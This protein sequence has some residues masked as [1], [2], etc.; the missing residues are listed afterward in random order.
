MSPSSLHWLNFVLYAFVLFHWSIFRLYLLIPLR[1]DNCFILFKSLSIFTLNKNCVAIHKIYFKHIWP[2]PS[3][4]IF[5]KPPNCI[6][7]SRTYYT[8]TKHYSNWT[9]EN[10]SEEGS[11]SR[12]WKKLNNKNFYETFHLPSSAMISLLV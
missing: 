6:K 10:I 1:L 11:L 4:K 8:L 9:K 7:Y 5:H 2:S 12:I 3:S